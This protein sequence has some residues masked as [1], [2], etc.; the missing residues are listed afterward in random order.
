M[1][2]DS[3]LSMSLD[4]LVMSDGQEGGEGGGRARGQ[5]RRGP[6]EGQPA[7]I[8]VGRRVYVGNLSWKTSWQVRYCRRTPLPRRP[9]RRPAT[10]RGPPA[11]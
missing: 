7:T 6:P 3:K 5:K 11:A 4:E 1:D 2:V 9:A 10:A 8:R